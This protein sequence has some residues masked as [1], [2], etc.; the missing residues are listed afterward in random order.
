[1]SLLYE[2]TSGNQV[3]GSPLD[4]STEAVVGAH[5]G[6]DPAPIGTL[7]PRKLKFEGEYVNSLPKRSEQVLNL[8][9]MLRLSLV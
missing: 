7:T 8:I 2:S 1:M 5:G 9:E 4:S 3:D 6:L